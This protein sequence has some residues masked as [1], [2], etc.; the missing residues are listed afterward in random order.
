MGRN[1]RPRAY[2]ASV[3]I[4]IQGMPARIARS[5]KLW[6]ASPLARGCL[7]LDWTDKFQNVKL[8]FQ[9]AAVAG[10]NDQ[11][12]PPS[13]SLGAFDPRYH[14]H[15]FGNHLEMVKPMQRDAD[16]VLLV[17]NRLTGQNRQPPARP[18]WTDAAK[19]ASED[20]L[21]LELEG[22]EDDAIALLQRNLHLGTDVMG[23]LAGRYKRRWLRDP[24]A[25]D[26]DGVRAREL[27]EEGLKLA[28]LAGDHAQAAYLAINGALM[29]LA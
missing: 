2:D 24:V 26:Q 14:C 15:V 29:H 9:L 18:Q 11:F 8:P 5:I 17:L 4:W 27:Y 16:S 28:E 25:G 6:V 12:V 7:R 13:S 22:R 10:N 23:T 20:A 1:D 21:A 3:E 19:Q